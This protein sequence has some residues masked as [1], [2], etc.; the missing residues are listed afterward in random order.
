M[1]STCST[2]VTKILPSP[3][4]P[5]PADRTIASIA[6]SSCFSGTTTSIFTLGRKSTT[7][8]APRQSSVS[9]F[10]RS[11]P[12]TSVTARPATPASDEAA[13]GDAPP[14][15]RLPALVLAPAD[16]ADDAAHVG[17]RVAQGDDLARRPV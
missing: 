3:I 10:W 17:R 5:V 9:P 14:R 16:Q 1:R 15:R 12:F 7:Y 11:K 2:V 6:G 4:L 8:S 13:R